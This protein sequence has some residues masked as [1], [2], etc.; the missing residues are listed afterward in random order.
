[1]AFL[2]VV[3]LIFTGVL[4]D[5]QVV[6]GSHYLEQSTVKIATREMVSAGRGD[7]LDCYG[8]VM[9]TNRA[10]YQVTLDTKQM[11]GIQGRNRTV[12]AL[13]DI[14]QAQG[15]VWE[16]SL[17]VS[18]ELPFQYTQE[19]P[20]QQTVTDENGQEN[21]YPTQLSKF[22]ELLK[23]KGWTEGKKP[24]AEEVVGALRTYFE[25][26][27]ELGEAEGRRLV[28]VLYELGLRNRDVSRSTYVFAQDVDIDFITAV[29]ERGLNGVRIETVAVRDYVTPYAGH[30]LGQVGPIYAEDK[31]YYQERGYNLNEIVGKFG[32]ESAFEDKLRGISGVKDVEL[33]QSGK[34]IRENWHVD[35]LTGEIMAP[36][37]GDHVMLTADLKLQEA[38]TKA[39]ERHVPGMTKDSEVAACVVTDMSGGILALASYPEYAAGDYYDR[40]TELSEDSRQPLFNRALQGLYAPG[41]TFKPAVAIGGLEEGVITRTEKI[42]DTGRYLHYDRIQDQPMCWYFRQYG[43]THGKVNVSEAIRDSC[44]IFFYETGLRMG[45]EALDRYAALFGLG[46]KTGLELYEEK[47]EI[48]GPETNERHGQQWYEGETMYAAIGQGNTQVTLIQLANYV[49][50]L[51]NGGY[52]YPTHLLKTVKSND[53]SQVVEEYEAQPRD[54]LELDPA[55]VEA[56][57]RGMWMVA[58]DSATASYFKDLPVEVGAKT[59]TSQVAGH[60]EADALMVAFAPYDDPEIAIAIVVEQGGSGSKVAAIAADI[61]EY[62]FSA[63]DTMDRI[64]VENTLLR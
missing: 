26:D 60:D 55:N 30:L 23:P 16:E 1:M 15:I 53:F 12:L 59:G 9:A 34:V 11:D 10:V 14:C 56:V 21:T 48:A 29:K 5:L 50:T 54:V 6:N 43:R 8:R 62:Y 4:Y 63:K 2:M 46:E 42:L 38:V 7:I 25:V 41:S 27:P 45:I 47:G 57:K 44:N 61:L 28:G 20:F 36:Q 31:E 22:L 24:T 19:D 58:N 52:H 32:V 18:R 3:V 35:T 40:Y 51:V 39:L 37:P 64:P 49:A 13:L 33:N 17:P